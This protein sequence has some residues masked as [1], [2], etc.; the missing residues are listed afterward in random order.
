MDEA[1]FAAVIEKRTST[2]KTSGTTIKTC[3]FEVA[4]SKVSPSVSKMVRIILLNF[5]HALNME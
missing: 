4:L 5:F 3:H 2:E 1:G